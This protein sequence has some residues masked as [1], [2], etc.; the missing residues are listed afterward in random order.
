[1]IASSSRLET[2]GKSEKTPKTDIIQNKKIT[3]AISRKGRGKRPIIHATKRTMTMSNKVILNPRRT[4]V[5]RKVS[6]NTSE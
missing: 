1:M 3:L 2:P 6:L 5:G 4:K